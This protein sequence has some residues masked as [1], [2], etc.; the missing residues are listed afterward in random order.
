MLTFVVPFDLWVG[1]NKGSDETGLCFVGFVVDFGS[2]C[3]FDAG[4]EKKSEEEVLLMSC[5]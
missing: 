2:G 4:R 5:C 3:H 1:G